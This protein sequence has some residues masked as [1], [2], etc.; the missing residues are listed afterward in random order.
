MKRNYHAA[1]F[2]T[3]TDCNSSV[4]GLITSLQLLQGLV[5][6]LNM[7]TRQSAACIKKL[8]AGGRSEFL[9]QPSSHEK[10]TDVHSKAEFLVL[11][12]N[13]NRAPG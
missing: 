7:H 4:H 3:G 9:T 1:L 11:S 5:C 13:A 2:V 8:P 12:I 6:I 10:F